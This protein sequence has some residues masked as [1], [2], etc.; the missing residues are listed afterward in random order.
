VLAGDLPRIHAL[1]SVA[2]TT[3]L[4]LFMP[5]RKAEALANLS[6]ADANALFPTMLAALSPAEPNAPA[7]RLVVRQAWALLDPTPARVADFAT[8]LDT[9]TLIAAPAARLVLRARLAGLLPTLLPV[10]V[11]AAPSRGQLLLAFLL[12]RGSA[13]RTTPPGPADPL[14]LQ[15]LHGI[16]AATRSLPAPISATL[17]AGFTSETSLLEAV[18]LGA[19]TALAPIAPPV[20]GATDLANAR[21]GGPSDVSND[22]F[23][24]GRRYTASVVPHAV[25]VRSGPQNS[26]PAVYWF[27]RG[28]PVRVLGV[29]HGWAAVEYSYRWDAG[30]TGRIGF[31]W[32]DLLSPVPTP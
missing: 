9:T 27:G 2:A 10:P 14:E 26:A 21:L 22:V 30:H 19:A 28:D 18:G 24:H 3:F 5:D 31:I 11:P 23:I 4:A 6:L 7:C 1:D 29:V 8:E 25:T 17:L 13:A 20:G 12:A 16:A 15:F 32:G